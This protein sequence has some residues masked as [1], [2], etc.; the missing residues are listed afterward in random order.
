MIDQPC[1]KPTWTKIMVISLLS[2][3][4]VVYSWF[5]FAGEVIVHRETE[6]LVS[7]ADYGEPI[8]ILV[9]VN[10]RP[11]DTPDNITV[12]YPNGTKTTLP[13]TNGQ[14][15]VNASMIGVWTFK[16]KNLTKEI[17]VNYPQPAII[18]RGHTSSN[19]SRYLSLFSMLFILVLIVSLILL[20]IFIRQIR[21][22]DLTFTK[23]MKGEQVI[24]R[25]RSKIPLKKVVIEDPLPKKILR[26]SLSEDVIKS[27]RVVWSVPKVEPGKPVE[28]TYYIKPAKGETIPPAKLSAVVEISGKPYN[29]SLTSGVSIDKM[30][31]HLSNITP[32][33]KKEKVSKPRTRKL[34]RY[35]KS[36]R[37][38]GSS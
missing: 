19:D 20:L 35:K 38:S 29:L 12:I 8:Y 27:G 4:T 31:V 5:P 2:M 11:L 1:V 13:L 33:K 9:K 37:G 15:V 34:P 36:E 22:A 30:N 14:V 10:G 26:S 16:Y 18:R 6:L 24:I 23:K 21:Q 28:L 25:L 17:D 32:I 3:L 7:S